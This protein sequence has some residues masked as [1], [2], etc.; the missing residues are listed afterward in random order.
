MD[1]LAVNA[2]N[3]F[4]VGLMASL[5]IGGGL[6]VVIWLASSNIP[7]LSPAAKVIAGVVHKIP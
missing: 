6:F 3:F 4:E 1:H 2:V 7:I 5:F